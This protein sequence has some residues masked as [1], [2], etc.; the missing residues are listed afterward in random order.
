MWVI[1]ISK[2]KELNSPIT[3]EFLSRQT[4]CVASSSIRSAALRGHS[5]H[6]WAP[7]SSKTDRFRLRHRSRLPSREESE[8]ILPRFPC[9]L[10]AHSSIELKL[11]CC[12]QDSPV[13]CLGRGYHLL[14]R[15]INFWGGWWQWWGGVPEK[16]VPIRL[17][18]QFWPW[19]LCVSG[20][21]GNASMA[22]NTTSLSPNHAGTHSGYGDLKHW[23]EWT[24]G[25][26]PR[27]PFKG[28]TGLP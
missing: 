10:L 28:N 9:Q 25:A 22:G 26:H 19:C 7:S 21:G 24:V 18:T 2:E 3:P 5:L 6:I 16:R 8:G 27:F 20:S 1:A 23:V 4:G 11:S 17:Y 15:T 12:T 13:K 14:I